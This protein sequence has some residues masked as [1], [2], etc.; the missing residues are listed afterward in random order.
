[1]AQ[2]QA[3][4]FHSTGPFGMAG[5]RRFADGELERSYA[6]AISIAQQVRPV[7]ALFALA[8]PTFDA[9]CSNKFLWCPG[10]LIH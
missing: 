8:T 2:A 3:K 6:P 5:L 1:L 10:E 9:P 4:N 7:L